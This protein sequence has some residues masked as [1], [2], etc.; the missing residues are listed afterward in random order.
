[1]CVYI[2]KA[3]TINARV[4]MDNTELLKMAKGRQYSIFVF[5][6]CDSQEQ[7]Y[8]SAGET[9]Q[10]SPLGCRLQDLK[11]I[12]RSIQGLLQGDYFQAVTNFLAQAKGDFSDVYN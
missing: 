10:R 3:K 5:M 2:N 12:S 8:I 11:E 4:Q 7:Q 6:M 9:Y 1:M